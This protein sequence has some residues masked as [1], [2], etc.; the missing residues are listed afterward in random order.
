[1]SKGIQDII[2]DPITCLTD[3]KDSS[4]ADR[5]LKQVTREL[6]Y[7]VKD[8]NFSLY[9]FCHL[10]APSGGKPH[11]EGGEVR[12]NQFANSRS[13]MRCCQ[14]MIGIERNK[15]AEDPLERNTSTFVLL[16]DRNFGNYAKFPVFYDYKTG[17]YLE[18]RGKI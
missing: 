1:M 13:M 14:Y 7:M 8:L 3:G 16:E 11:E 12:S 18:P 6:D 2:I 5:L 17:N 15:K 10:N 9:V 4:E